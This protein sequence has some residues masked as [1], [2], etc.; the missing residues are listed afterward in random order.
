MDAADDEARERALSQHHW[1][2]AMRA[3]ASAASHF[4]YAARRGS[5]E[6]GELG[7]EEGDEYAPADQGFEEEYGEYGEYG[8]IDGDGSARGVVDGEM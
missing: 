5:E 8:D 3:K 7:G 2:G 1:G 4:G 6:L